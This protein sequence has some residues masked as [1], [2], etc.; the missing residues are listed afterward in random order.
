M[1]VWRV[2]HDYQKLLTSP[3]GILFSYLI[4]DP[5]QR[6][7]SQLFYLFSWFENKVEISDHSS[8][9]LVSKSISTYIHIYIYTYIHIYKYTYIPI[10]CRGYEI[11]E[12]GLGNPQMSR[13]GPWN[14]R[15]PSQ[16]PLLL[17]TLYLICIYI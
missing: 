13:V 12:R 15:R 9:T 5:L 16:L 10:Y 2:F 1:Y 4:L 8:H 17:Y 6:F 3:K 14:R 7:R 11:P